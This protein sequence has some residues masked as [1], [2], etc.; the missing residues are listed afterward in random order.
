MRACII[1]RGNYSKKEVRI[2]EEV[3]AIGDRSCIYSRYDWLPQRSDRAGSAVREDPG[4]TCVT[5]DSSPGNST[6]ST[7]K[8][9]RGLF[10]TEGGSI[11]SL[12][13]YPR[14]SIELRICSSCMS[15]SRM[16]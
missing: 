4:S 2:H 11:C 10:F 5:D 15:L 12:F 13:F 8:V 9:I 3:H 14:F 6:R 7:G 16:L 1:A